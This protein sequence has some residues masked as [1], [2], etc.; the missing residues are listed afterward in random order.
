M[1]PHKNTAQQDNTQGLEG[2]NIADA[3]ELFNILLA[4]DTQVLEGPDIADVKALSNILV[5]GTHNHEV[6]L[7]AG[8][9]LERNTLYC[10]AD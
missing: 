4:T 8:R 7:V 3:R 6:F 2:P 1:S 9:V 5:V 10:S